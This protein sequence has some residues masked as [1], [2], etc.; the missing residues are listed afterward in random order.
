MFLDRSYGVVDGCL[1]FDTVD[2]FNKIAMDI[3]H[4]IH[5][6]DITTI[7]NVGTVSRTV[8]PKIFIFDC[9]I[10]TR[11]SLGFFDRPIDMNK[12]TTSF[13]AEISAVSFNRSVDYDYIVFPFITKMGRV[14]HYASLFL[15][16]STKVRISRYTYVL[17]NNMSID[18]LYCYFDCKKC[19][20]YDSK[21]VIEDLE[22]MNFALK[23]MR[24][25]SLSFGVSF[26]IDN[27]HATTLE[28]PKESPTNVNDCGVFICMMNYALCT[29]KDMKR[30]FDA[31]EIESIRRRIAF[32]LSHHRVSYLFF[33]FF[34]YTVYDV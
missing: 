2:Y 24:S 15:H 6:E 8:V 14:H 5:S 22:C 32:L 4:F 12:I 31:N 20:F 13:R 28:G 1:D 17:S 29:G 3:N 34:T 26:D 10:L 7:A 16:R 9:M 27:W 21:G 30:S 33:C 19:L 23:F 25:L 11:F 18:K